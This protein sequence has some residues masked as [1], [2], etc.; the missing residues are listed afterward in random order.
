MR[1]HEL[2]H[3][4]RIRPACTNAATPPVRT[5]PPP[6]ARGGSRGRAR[7]RSR[8]ARRAR[9]RHPQPGRRGHKHRPVR[10]ARPRRRTSA[11]W[12][13]TTPSTP[14]S[15]RPCAH[16]RRRTE[17]YEIAKAAGRERGG[18]RGARRRRGAAARG[19]GATAMR[20]IRQA[21]MDSRVGRRADRC[22]RPAPAARR[23]AARP[24]LRGRSGPRRPRPA[25]HRGH[26]R[27]RHHPGHRRR[28]GGRAGRR[29]H[30]HAAGR[31]P[32]GAG[33]GRRAGRR[34]ARS[35]AIAEQLRAPARRSWRWRRT[36][37]ARSCPRACWTPPPRRPAAPPPSALGAYP[38][39][40]KLVLSQV[41]D[42]AGHRPAAA[43]L[44]RC[45]TDVGAW[46]RTPA[47]RPERR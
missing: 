41:H 18:S 14:R 10:A 42:R 32:R 37:S 43:G 9:A 46:P 4:A 25:V 16:R 12:T 11:T 31:A 26:G 35:P 47:P 19:P 33:D 29:D 17:R 15:R 40:G 8:R 5:A 1:R 7:A 38:A 39:I 45:R 30:R 27:R 44:A 34:R 22:P 23:G 3:W 20:R 13:A 21:V 36:W 24:A 28:R 2:P 6:G